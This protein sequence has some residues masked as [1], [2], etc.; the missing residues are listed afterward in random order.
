MAKSNLIY[1]GNVRI[2]TSKKKRNIKN[3]GKDPLFKLL[4][5]FLAGYSINPAELP[6]F[7]DLKASSE[8]TSNTVPA[9]IQPVK[10]QISYKILSN[11]V[12]ATIYTA[13]I[14]D[15]NLI[16]MNVK[17]NKYIVELKDGTPQNNVLAEI[18]ITNDIIS[19]ITI[20]RQA[21][22]EW[23]LTIGNAAI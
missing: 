17:Y 19:E 21:L 1:A 11:G 2:T 6:T 9:I 10:V 22:V 18:Q 13:N 3:N 5:R 15:T 12:P 20:G 23:E 16:Q 14:T 7:I 8:G 4:C